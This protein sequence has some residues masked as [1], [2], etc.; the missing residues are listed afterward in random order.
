LCCVC[1]KVQTKP[2]RCGCCA[3]GRLEVG[4]CN[5][6]GPLRLNHC[7]GMTRVAT[8]VRRSTPDRAWCACG[9]RYAL[10]TVQRLLEVLQRGPPAQRSPTLL[11]LRCLLEAPA[12]RLGPAALY[13]PALFAPVAALLHGPCAADALQV[14][15][16]PA[17][18]NGT[19]CPRP[20]SVFDLPTDLG[21][22]ATVVVSLAA[23]TIPN[24][25]QAPFMPC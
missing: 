21:P 3:S 19:A 12:L 1:A 15:T 14:G 11:L 2:P 22:T 7:C 9:A 16:L 24:E 18:G 8:T 25:S 4:C 23:I 20:C 6:Q 17:D 10:L 13:S 5:C